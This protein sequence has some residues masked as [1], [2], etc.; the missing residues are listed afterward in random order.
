M[1][2]EKQTIEVSEDKHKALDAFLNKQV[3]KADKKG[4]QMVVGRAD[5]LPEEFNSI[6]LQPLGYPLFDAW[7]APENGKG[8]LPIGGTITFQGAGSVGKTS[9]ALML[10]ASFQKKG[11]T[12]LYVDFERT[13]DEKWAQKLG[14]DTTKLHVASPET[15]E[16]GLD[17]IEQTAK[18]GLLDAVIF[19]SLDSAIPEGSLHKKGSGDK[20]G[21]SKDIDE[22][23]IALKPRKLSQWFPRV[24]FYFR[25]YNTLL[26]FIAQQRIQLTAAGGYPGMAG[27][28][29]LAHA[30]L[31]NLK[32]YR[33]NS[34]DD[35]IINGKSIAYKMRIKVDKSKCPGL[36]KDDEMETYFFHEG[37]FNAAF[38]AVALSLEGQLENSP[39]SKTS[40]QSSLYV[41]PAGIEH[42]IAGAKPA[43]VYTKLIEEG[44]I[45]SFLQTVGYSQ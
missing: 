20:H 8:G 16:R 30:N 9:T 43:T 7:S 2:E 45:D 38:E 18:E 13:F 1:S 25:K 22:D 40:I 37:G 35:L 26:V 5:K 27:G 33:N 4:Y 34:K 39:L 15:L 3:K 24:N 36:R 10:A 41:D 28:N 32:M 17:T 23:T 6:T 12:V 21:A 31:L 44:L 14:V 29:A 42:K 11:K 19:D